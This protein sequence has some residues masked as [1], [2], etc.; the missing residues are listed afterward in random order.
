MIS[1]IRVQ[2]PV[3]RDQCSVVSGLWNLEIDISE[4]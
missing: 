1:K 2:W 3:V 4:M